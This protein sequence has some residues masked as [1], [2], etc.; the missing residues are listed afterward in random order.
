LTAKP[1]E[2]PQ[3]GSDRVQSV[4]RAIRL[5]KAV[6]A[7][8]DA[9]ASV[10]ALAHRCGLNRATAWRI[11]MTLESEG[12]VRRDPHNGWFSVG[13]TILQLRRSVRR[14]SLVEAARPVLERLS[15]ETGEPACLGVIEGDEIHYVA[16]AIPAI[17]N[18]QS[19]LG[20]PV[21][22]H[23][24]S[25]GKAFLAFIDQARVRQLLG[26]A[27]PRYTDATLTRLDEIYVELGV[28]R[29]RGYAISRGEIEEG[30]WGVAAPIFGAEGEPVAALSLWGPDQRGGWERLEAL[31]R[32]ARQ[33]AREL[34]SR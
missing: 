23:A 10:A 19:W 22:L 29:S 26:E 24:S 21:Y 3:I 34:S 8:A 33:A 13:P 18:E 25:M 27:P 30:S 1:A 9:D 12:V 15:L 14:D 11:L 7:S 31:G 5:L 28:I 17:A 16:E 32:L 4:Y 6:A 20:R 2:A